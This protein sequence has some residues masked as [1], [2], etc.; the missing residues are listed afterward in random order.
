MAD[1]TEELAPPK[2]S[3][4]NAEI[5]VPFDMPFSMPFSGGYQTQDDV[6]EISRFNGGDEPTVRQLVNM[7]K[8]D[9]QAR[10]LY[11][12]ITLPVRS[13]LS[14]KKIVA[15]PDGDEEADF[16]S[17]MFNLPASAGGMQT[18]LNTFVSQILMALFDGF[19]GFELVYHIPKKGDL[20]GKITLKKAAYRPS[21]SLTFLTGPKGEFAGFRQQLS[22]HGKAVDTSIPPERCFYFAAQEEERPFYGV[23][24]F[25]SAFYHY[26]KKEKLYYLA[27][28]AA[29]HRAVGSR[30]GEIPANASRNDI[31]RF[32]SALGDY[33]FAQGI[34]LPP[35]F[36]VHNEYPGA[37]YDFLDIINHHN[38][39]MSK[40]VLA[41]FFDQQQGGDK[42]LVDFGQQSD[43]MFIM[44][45]QSIMAEI[46]DAINDKII[47]RFIDW[48][49]G[50][51]KYPT[52][53]WGAFTDD[54]KRS[55]ITIF[56]RLA[57][58]GAGVNVSSEF[59]DQLEKKV[60]EDL[61]FRIDYEAIAA[62][63]AATGDLNPEDANA[64]RAFLQ[65][66]GV[67][68]ST[69]SPESAPVESTDVEQPASN[70]GL[71]ADSVDVLDTSL[72][73]E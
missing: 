53:T 35:G 60:S 2:K 9:G 67:A 1:P 16:I 45:L 10:A 29:Q 38:S 73:D 27:H 22:F 25:Q 48:N 7:R 12:L 11:R 26:D 28:L 39:Q 66:A 40:S 15:A 6:Y 34:V 36:R 33:G 72:S 13:A 41:A 63:R 42:T 70:M 37:A 52:F 58:A 32:R 71:T 47:P 69:A 21:E 4:L 20:Q 5:G 57:T 56:D 62:R 23:S 18:S 51:G 19:A 68:I 30:V 31:A 54:Q 61:G 17:K 43:A 59:L 8:R 49:F 64:F 50:T 46:A 24:Y 3:D 65:E 55:I 14:T 44:M